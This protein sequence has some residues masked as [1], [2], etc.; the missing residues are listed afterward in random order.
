MGMGGSMPFD[1]AEQDRMTQARLDRERVFQR[2]EREQQKF[3]RR[4]RVLLLG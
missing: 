4:I 3:E 1:P 2:Q